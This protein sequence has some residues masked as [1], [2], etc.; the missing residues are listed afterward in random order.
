MKIFKQF[1]KNGKPCPICG[2]KKSGQVTLIPIDGTEKD[3]ISEAMQVHVDCI[4]LRYSP[5]MSR[6]Y[7]DAKD[8]VK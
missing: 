8:M 1:N 2:T 5:L 4:E 3:H 7:M 6:I